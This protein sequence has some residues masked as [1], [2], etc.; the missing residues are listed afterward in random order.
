MK[1]SKE[2][3]KLRTCL[4]RAIEIIANESSE[5][6]TFSTECTIEKDGDFSSYQSPEIEPNLEKVEDELYRRLGKD[7]EVNFTECIENIENM[8]TS[9]D[10]LLKTF[11]SLMV[12]QIGVHEQVDN[13]KTKNP[14]DED[15]YIVRSPQEE[16]KNAKRP[17][18]DNN[19]DGDSKEVSNHTPVNYGKEME[20]YDSDEMEDHSREAEIERLKNLN[21]KSYLGMEENNEGKEKADYFKRKSFP[22]GNDSEEIPEEMQTDEPQY[23]NF[24]ED[25]WRKRIA[26]EKT[27]VDDDIGK[28]CK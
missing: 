15:N 19:M 23:W 14:D 28:F 4:T 11:H 6:D 17:H 5:T 25:D 22:I 9:L 2:R 24:S 13:E 20:E 10:Y 1:S 16:T 3:E 7:Q 26:L 18:P 21:M 8:K 12:N 27:F